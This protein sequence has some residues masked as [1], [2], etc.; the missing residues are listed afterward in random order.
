MLQRHPGFRA[1][2]HTSTLSSSGK[3]RSDIPSM[4]FT[5]AVS[6]LSSRSLIFSQQLSIHAAVSLSSLQS[7]R[8]SSI[9]PSNPYPPGTTN[10]PPK[11]TPSTP[12]PDQPTLLPPPEPHYLS[13]LAPRTCILSCGPPPAIL[14]RLVSSQS[15]HQ[16]P[17]T[18]ARTVQL[19]Q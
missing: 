4:I 15:F 8:P 6:F 17:W 14:V 2:S 9:P 11:Q 10:P 13:P 12:K 18:V 16:G 1:F 7:P 3:T 5:V 19:L